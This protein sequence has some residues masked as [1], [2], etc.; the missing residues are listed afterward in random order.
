[1]HP[2]NRSQGWRHGGN[3][4]NSSYYRNNGGGGG[5]RWGSSSGGDRYYG[6]G[7]TGNHGQ[8]NSSNNYQR[9]YERGSN[10]GGGYT[11]NQHD[12]Y[13]GSTRD[14]GRAG[15]GASGVMETQAEMTNS[16]R[17]ADDVAAGSSTVPTGTSIS[18]TTAPIPFGFDAIIAPQKRAKM[19]ETVGLQQTMTTT[20]SPPPPTNT[21][22][23]ILADLLKTTCII[24][25]PP[26]EQANKD[27][28]VA[29]LREIDRS[30]DYVSDQAHQLPGGWDEK[31]LAAAEKT[32]EELSSIRRENSTEFDDDEESDDSDPFGRTTNSAPTVGLSLAEKNFINA[33][34]FCIPLSAG[35]HVLR[36]EASNICYCPCGPNLEPWR[37]RYKLNVDHNCGKHSKM[38]TPNALMDHLKVEGGC[39]EEKRHGKK[40]FVPIQDIYHHA[41]NVYLRNL[42]ADWFRKGFAHKAL[43]P[44]QSKEHQRAVNEELRII[45]HKVVLGTRELRKVEEEKEKLKAEHE[46]LRAELKMKEKVL[47][48]LDKDRRKAVEKLD[49]LRE[50]FQ[51]EKRERV[52]LTDHQLAKFKKVTSNYFERT[53]RLM[54]MPKKAVD[55]EINSI[56]GDTVGFKLQTFFDDNYPVKKSHA[57]AVLFEDDETNSFKIAKAILS[58]WNIIYDNKGDNSFQSKGKRHTQAR[59]Q[60]HTPE[61]SSAI[62][63]CTNVSTHH[64]L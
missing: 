59:T 5:G 2:N 4:N 58:N 3:R 19:T 46:K 15:A 60:I 33:L 11:A 53:K 35:F 64:V 42:F 55:F 16:K 12:Q 20:A 54:G 13:Y 22:D 41:T 38:F 47:S 29:C 32:I 24:S 45:E 37:E 26:N 48:L 6:G 17:P 44:C 25:I 61:E 28:F 8:Y 52:P 36:P 10:D 1:M 14:N 57:S 62:Y 31:K 39:Y 30:L 40:V 34:P 7:A 63:A 21:E 50:R 27:A 43:F 23:N 9:Q 49:E 51:V 56:R 18:A